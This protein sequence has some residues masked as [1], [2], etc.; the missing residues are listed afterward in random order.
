MKSTRGVFF[1]GEY[2]CEFAI[3]I[4][5]WTTNDPWLTMD[6]DN[7]EYSKCAFYNKDRPTCALYIRWQKPGLI[8]CSDLDLPVDL[9][10]K[11]GK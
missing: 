1:R 5:C 2:F 11:W 10:D 9:N 8:I 6:A 3:L 4:L 7:E